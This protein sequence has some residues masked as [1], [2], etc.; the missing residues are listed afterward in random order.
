MSYLSKIGILFLCVLRFI[1]SGKSNALLH[2][3]KRFLVFHSGKLGDLVC[4]T[5]IFRAIK[6]NYPNCAVVVMGRTLNRELLNFNLDVD[7]YTAYE[8]SFFALVRSIR[9]LHIDA[10][11]I[12]TLN[13]RGLAAIYVAGVS[14]IVSLRVAG[15]WSPNETKSYRLAR[16]LTKIVEY[17]MGKYASLENLRMLK[18]F[19]IVSEDTTKHLSFSDSARNKI[20]QFFQEQRIIEL[21]PII[22]I[23]PGAGNKIKQWNPEKF[24]AV[25][26]SVYDKHNATIL[27]LGS[28]SDRYEAERMIT[29]LAPS[30]KIINT[31]SLF[32]IDELKACI[33]MLDIVVSVDSATIYIAEAFGVATVDITGPIDER[34]QPPIGPRHIVV[35]PPHR[36][37]PQL[38]V[39]NARVYD[40]DEAR[41]QVESITIDMVVQEI[42][43]MTLKP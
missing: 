6:K 41:R 11:C 32:N 29:S 3:P 19:G 16:C 4:A 28:S 23:A 22:G 38:F 21:H 42:N 36:T 12:A 30:T 14:L 10:A 7:K 40:A 31:V 33:S 18:P 13:F 8:G 1:L 9:D 34:E 5:P 37:H 25:A 39:M 35:T 20:K 24:A 43:K 17:R 2:H 26:D 15:G 27:V